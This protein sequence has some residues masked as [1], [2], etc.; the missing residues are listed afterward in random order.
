V[1]QED[2]RVLTTVRQQLDGYGREMRT[3]SER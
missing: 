1:V 2:T 3:D